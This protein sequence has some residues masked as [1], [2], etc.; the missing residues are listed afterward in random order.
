M[1]TI[2]ETIRRIST[3]LDLA[4][5]ESAQLDAEILVRHVLE[6]DRTHLLMALPD[7]FPDDKQSA[8]DALVQ[9]RVLSEPISLLTGHREFFGLDFVV[10]PAVLTPRPETELLIEWALAWVRG[11]PGGQVVDVGT[12]SGA[13]AI[14]MAAHTGPEVHL[15]GTDISPDALAVAR[16]NAERLVPGR[17]EFLE[18]DLLDTI[19]GPFDLILANLPY[20]TPSQLHDRRELAFE[21]ELALVSGDDGLHAIRRLIAQIPDRLQRPGAACL[22]I[23]PS[24]AEEVVRL[25]RTTMPGAEVSVQNDL[26]RRERLVTLVRL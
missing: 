5:S 9:R 1:P 13:I 15:L 25:L 6:L 2:A 17:I 16:T 10:S 19:D 11:H 12:G 26:A 3:T 4:G 14:A 24:Q 18:A 23:D 21:P 8:L 22:E 20:L 7:P